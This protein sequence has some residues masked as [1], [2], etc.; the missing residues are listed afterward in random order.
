MVPKTAV[1]LA[2]GLGSRM[3]KKPKGLL[4]VAGREIIYRTMR[5]LEE[6]RVSRF[7]IVTNTQYSNL[8]KEFV[9]RNGFNAGI[10]INPEPERGNGY[11][12]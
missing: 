1:V 4:E 10:V 6:P 2:A 8:Y 3:G 12:L 5:T 9:E 7:V 11:S